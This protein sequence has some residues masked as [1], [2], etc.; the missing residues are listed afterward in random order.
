MGRKKKGAVTSPKPFNV[1]YEKKIGDYG[2]ASGLL[3]EINDFLKKYNLFDA[4]IE[5]RTI[6]DYYDTVLTELWITYWGPPTI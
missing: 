3:C 1:N 6:P 5:I 2:S 4:S